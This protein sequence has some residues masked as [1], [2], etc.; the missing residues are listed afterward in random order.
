[1]VRIERPEM[2]SAQRDICVPVRSLRSAR[3]EAAYRR[4]QNPTARISIWDKTVEPFEML[5]T[6]P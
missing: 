4:E 2:V 3:R 6:I 5:E 1:L